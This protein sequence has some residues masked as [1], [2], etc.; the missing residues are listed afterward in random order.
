MWNALKEG[1]I[2]FATQMNFQETRNVES[3][4]IAFFMK[5]KADR[6][7]FCGL[8]LQNLVKTYI[9]K[10]EHNALNQKQIKIQWAFIYWFLY[11]ES[12]V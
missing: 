12:K 6:C 11:S 2:L 4:K 7:R 5:G 10:R 3:Q 1:M 9:Y 8:K